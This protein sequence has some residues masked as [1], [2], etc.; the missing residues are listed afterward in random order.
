MDGGLEDCNWRCLGV[1][2]KRGVW[3]VADVAE[4]GSPRLEFWVWTEVWDGFGPCRGPFLYGES[5]SARLRVGEPLD[6]LRE[7]VYGTWSLG[8]GG[9]GGGV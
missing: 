2:R 8:T 1:G 7:W 5:C 3:D 6:V 4:L 9:G